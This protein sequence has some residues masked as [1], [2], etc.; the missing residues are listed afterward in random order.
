MIW[1]E[2]IICHGIDTLGVLTAVSFF[3][4]MG[5]MALYFW[6]YNKYL[7]KKK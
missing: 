2:T 6:I 5:L 3:T 4:G 7:K 1:N